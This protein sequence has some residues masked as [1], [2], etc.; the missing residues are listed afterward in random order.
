MK[1]KKDKEPEQ[2]A[3]KEPHSS[4][5]GT[6]FGYSVEA[7]ID[8]F[9]PTHRVE[10]P[11]PLMSKP[12][13]LTEKWQRVSFWEGNN[14]CGVPVA[15]YGHDEH[16]FS[17]HGLLERGSAI[18]LAYTLAAQN[19]RSSLTAIKI[20]IVQHKLVYAHKVYLEGEPEELNQHFGRI[21][22]LMESHFNP[23]RDRDTV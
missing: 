20:R 3:Q 21:D 15:G 13:V 12:M 23:S 9:N 17:I 4:Q 11:Q 5:N 1:F 8:H 19:S 7:R 18:A 22:D 6:T 16:L 14:P 10:I 2:I